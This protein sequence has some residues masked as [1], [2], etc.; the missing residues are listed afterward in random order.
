MKRNVFTNCMID[1]ITCNHVTKHF[2]LCGG[3]LINQLINYFL[4]MF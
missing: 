1:K 3:I 2:N 4:I